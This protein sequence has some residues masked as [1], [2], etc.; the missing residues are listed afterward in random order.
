MIVASN[1]F[2]RFIASLRIFGTLVAGAVL[3]A[4]MTTALAG[5]RAAGCGGNAGTAA[6]LSPIVTQY[7]GR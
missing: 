5:W 6:G 4:G 3:I 2:D 7:Q 1:T